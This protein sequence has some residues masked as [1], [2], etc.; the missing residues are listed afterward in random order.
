MYSVKFSKP[1][2][3]LAKKIQLIFLCL[4]FL[5]FIHIIS[6]VSTIYVAHIIEFVQMGK[7]LLFY[8]LNLRKFNKKENFVFL[9]LFHSFMLS[10]HIFA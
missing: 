10:L 1:T 4:P 8:N 9:L 5:H 3:K 2:A 6:I 7:V